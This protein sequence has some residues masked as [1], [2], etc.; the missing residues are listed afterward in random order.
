MLKEKIEVLSSNAQV[1]LIALLLM[2]VIFGLSLMVV[3][4]LNLTALYALSLCL[5][6]WRSTFKY[7]LAGLAVIS[8]LAL[9]AALLRSGGFVE[10]ANSALALAALWGLS[11]LFWSAKRRSGHLQADLGALKGEFKILRRK[12]R[13]ATLQAELAK[14]A[15][16][17]LLTSLSHELRTPLN[18][19]L[20]FAD[21]IQQERF[22]PFGNERY[23]SYISHI[24]DSGAHLLRLID[25]LLN[26]CD[27]ETGKVDIS[28]GLLEPGKIISESLDAFAPEFQ[29]KNITAV[30]DLAESPQLLRA[31][32]EKFRQ[33][34]DNLLS[35]AIAF[36]DEGGQVKIRAWCHEKDGYVFQIDDTGVG[37]R[38]REVQEAI[39]PFGLVNG[40]RS[41]LARSGLGLT[42][43]K[44]LVE[45]HSGSMDVQSRP[46][47]GTCV[48][49]RFP[50]QRT[51]AAP[52]LQADAPA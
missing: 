45:L 37:I 48:T 5:L 46:G 33:I 36:T 30:A 13:N 44:S 31:D 24:E 50:A 38:L 10:T 4:G 26:V 51:T 20:G 49:L 6:W 28:E 52:A 29:A 12:E 47:G 23:K 15:H 11:G 8:L 14:A 3:P 1:E 41:K 21:I 25:N 9:A 34:L 19:I 42:I 2:G 40:T 17:D 7:Q 32:G 43:S 39:R 22:G 35:N 16:S 27:L 18:A